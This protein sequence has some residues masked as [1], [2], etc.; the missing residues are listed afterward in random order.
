M[1]KET[2]YNQSKAQQRHPRFGANVLVRNYWIRHAQKISGEITNTEGNAW[3]SSSISKHGAKSAKKYGEAIT[4]SKDGAKGYVSSSMRTLQTL[5][6]IFEGYKQ[7]NPDKPIYPARVVKEL[8]SEAVPEFLTL[9][10]L[11]FIMHRKKILEQ[12][13]ILESNFAFLTPDEQEEIAELAE[14]PVM[15]EWLD[16]PSSELARLLPP[17]QAAARFARLF[18][19]RHEKLVTKLH[20]GSEM[21]LFHVTHKT[22]TEPFLVS[23]VLVRKTDKKRITGLE[24]LGG[25]LKILEDWQS[26]IT[27]DRFGNLNVVVK[28]RGEE[29]EIDWQILESLLTISLKNNKT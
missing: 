5:E 29:Y 11:K 9:Y 4:A 7:T 18:S 25:S 24:Q 16:N 6:K 20:S 8:G 15:R 23:G 27:T 3:S 13:K 28:F 22:I 21:D 14:E 19:R 2:V 17:Q 12:R 10:N 1:V 26:I